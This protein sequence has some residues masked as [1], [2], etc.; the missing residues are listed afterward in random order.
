MVLPRDHAG[1][2]LQTPCCY[3]FLPLAP[4]EGPTFIVSAD[5]ELGMEQSTQGPGWRIPK[6][7]RVEMSSELLGKNEYK[8]TEADGGR[9][10]ILGREGTRSRLALL[11]PEA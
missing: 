8:C 2:M 6:T 9:K 10:G 4:T 7:S 1:S 11:H 3:S 5:R